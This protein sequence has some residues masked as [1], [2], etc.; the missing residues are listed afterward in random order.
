MD[1]YITAYEYE[2]NVNPV[3]KSVPI[4][5]KNAFECDYGIT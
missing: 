3:L 4:L 2:K 5:E 1:R